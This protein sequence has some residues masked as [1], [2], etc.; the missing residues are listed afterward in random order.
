MLA[1][2][3]I[4]GRTKIKKI[5]RI[6]IAGADVIGSGDVEVILLKEG[7]TITNTKTNRVVPPSIV[8]VTKTAGYT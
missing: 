3:Y 1:V 7:G 4:R 8:V 6:L 5:D 2:L